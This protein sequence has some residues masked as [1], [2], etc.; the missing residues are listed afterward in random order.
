MRVALV[1][2]ILLAGLL[3]Y[4]RLAPTSAAKWHQR[5]AEVA[6][7][8]RLPQPTDGPQAMPGGAYAAVASDL[9]GVDL[10]T[11][12]DAIALATPRTRRIAGTPQSGMITWETRSA[13]WGFPDYTTAEATSDATHG[14]MLSL[15]ARLRFGSSDLGVNG[16]RLGLWLQELSGQK[17]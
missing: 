16:A 13:V 1:A 8:L 4:I 7:G 11:R 10:L 17:R 12:L 5:P 3:A 2:A 14:T 6:A 9:G 15:V